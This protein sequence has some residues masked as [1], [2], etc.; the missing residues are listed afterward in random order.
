MPLQV[1]LPRVQRLP[2]QVQA[3]V[4][5]QQRLQRRPQ[6]QKWLRQQ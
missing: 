2:E 4:Q 5:L 6:V 3:Q 1:Q